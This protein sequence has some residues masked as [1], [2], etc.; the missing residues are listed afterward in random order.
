M[1][2]P[3][4]PFFPH[5]PLLC[6][7]FD[8]EIKTMFPSFDTY[9]WSSLFERNIHTCLEI[10]QELKLL[11]KKELSIWLISFGCCCDLEALPKHRNVWC[12]KNPA[13]TKSPSLQGVEVG[14]CCVIIQ[15]EKLLSGISDSSTRGSLFCCCCL[16]LTVTDPGCHL[17]QHIL[18][19][20]TIYVD[21]HGN[22]KS[23]Y[24]T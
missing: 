19:L 1:L 3:P 18:S 6:V 13:C 14:H 16:F 12:Q 21:V 8:H 4:P 5:L 10:G 22:N 11:R 15:K 9:N 7:R 20:A 23:I 2:I 24:K 17:L